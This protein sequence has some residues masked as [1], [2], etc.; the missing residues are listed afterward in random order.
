MIKLLSLIFII[1]LSYNTA[2]S[3]VLNSVVIDP[4]HGG[5]DFGIRSAKFKEKDFA[6]VTAKEVAGHF[7]TSGKTVTLTRK[8]DRLLSIKDRVMETDK[9]KPDVFVSLHVTDSKIFYIYTAWYSKTAEPSV[10]QLHEISYR[11]KKFK[12]K[13]K[14][15][16]DALSVELKKEFNTGVS[17]RELTLPLLGSV[18]APAVMLEVPSIYLNDSITAKKIANAIAEGIFAYERK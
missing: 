7:K 5:Y 9:A 2:Y 13:S 17:A 11:Q 10:K 14:T 6:L 15:L 3:Q 16:S 18:Y 4:G 12:E 8:I 1:I